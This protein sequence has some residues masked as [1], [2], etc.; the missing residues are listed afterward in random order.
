MND[1]WKNKP[2]WTLR[3]SEGGMWEVVGPDGNVKRQVGIGE[4]ALT[5]YLE[6]NQPPRFSTE[7][8]YLAMAN[9]S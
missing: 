6:M 5:V 4:C 3:F 9:R 2:H 8:I 7:G 1:D